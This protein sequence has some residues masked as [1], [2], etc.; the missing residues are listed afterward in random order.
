LPRT[1]DLIASAVRSGFSAL[2]GAVVVAFVAVLRR[3][4]LRRGQRALV[5]DPPPGWALDLGPGRRRGFGG[6]CLASRLS[7]STSLRS[8]FTFSSA[9]ARSLS[10]FEILSLISSA[11]RT[12]IAACF[13]NSSFAS[14]L[15]SGRPL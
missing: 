12:L 11:I 2:D 3:L 14:G 5:G 6:G 13:W 8:A 1:I 9:S 10:V 15:I 4:L 7:A